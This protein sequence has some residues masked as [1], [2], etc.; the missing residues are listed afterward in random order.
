MR[1]Y[2]LLTV[3]HTALCSSY[4]TAYAAL[5]IKQH[6]DYICVH[7]YTSC[8]IMR[9][10]LKNSIITKFMRMSTLLTALCAEI[11]KEAA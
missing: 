10:S 9:K 8:R 3:Y 4:E 5:A 2:G 7:V 11:H 1:T 6:S